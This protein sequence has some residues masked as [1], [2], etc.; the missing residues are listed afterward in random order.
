MSGLRVPQSAT[1]QT[2]PYSTHSHAK[3]P[4]P[5]LTVEEIALPDRASYLP[6]CR[7][8]L[9]HVPVCI[10]NA[11]P[12]TLVRWVQTV[13][14]NPHQSDHLVVR[15]GPV[16]PTTE[17][18]RNSLEQLSWRIPAELVHEMNEMGEMSGAPHESQSSIDQDDSSSMTDDLSY[19]S[20]SMPSVPTSVI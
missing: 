19:K 17:V 4:L 2:A 9:K 15:S 13:S 14:L 7:L 6:S 3:T 20:E 16:I 8:R 11:I 10:A 1:A 5:T 18:I 12:R